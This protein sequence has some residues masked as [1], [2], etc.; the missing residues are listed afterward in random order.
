MRISDWS[1]DVC[2]SDLFFCREKRIKKLWS[3]CGWNSRS[4]ITDFDNH[5]V[6]GPPRADRQLANFRFRHG[7]H[8]VP[9]KVQSNLLQLD[10]IH[11]D[12]QQIVTP[13]FH[14]P[15]AFSHPLE[16]NCERRRSKERRVGKEWAS[17]G[18]L[19]GSPEI[20]KKK[21]KT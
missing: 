8:R 18:R 9:N 10:D 21:R 20:D 4:G 19:R 2:S 6:A 11:A 3:I 14:N 17:P 12:K 5:F 15:V 13:P 7:F 16:A 1:S